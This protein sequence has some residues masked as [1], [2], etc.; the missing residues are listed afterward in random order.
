M[1]EMPYKLQNDPEQQQ[2]LLQM[3]ADQQQ[4]YDTIY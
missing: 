3:A 2:I 1:Y 4:I